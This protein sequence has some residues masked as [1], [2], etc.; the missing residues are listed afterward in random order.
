MYPFSFY[1]YFCFLHVLLIFSQK[2]SAKFPN[3]FK[4]PITFILLLLIT[5]YIILI[6]ILLLTVLFY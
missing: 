6:H 3:L 1:I 4:V 5:S 2:N